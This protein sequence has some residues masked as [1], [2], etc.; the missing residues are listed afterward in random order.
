M[1]HG[2]LEI[3]IRIL[4]M[5]ACNKVTGVDN[6]MQYEMKIYTIDTKLN[7]RELIFTLLVVDIQKRARGVFATRLLIA[8]PAIDIFL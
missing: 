2:C 5:N 4:S 1:L 6:T 8:C 3:T 7:S